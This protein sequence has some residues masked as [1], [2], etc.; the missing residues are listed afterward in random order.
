MRCARN[1]SY[2]IMNSKEMSLEEMRASWVS[3]AC[4][5]QYHK[6]GFDAAEHATMTRRVE[7]LKLRI[8]TWELAQ[9]EP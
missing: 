8:K 9:L 2:Y 1:G 3:N 6:H 5:T 7:K 4:A